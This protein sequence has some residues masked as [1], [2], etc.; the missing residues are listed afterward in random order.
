[1]GWGRTSARG[2]APGAP[3]A[4]AAVAG[5]P[6]AFWASSS[7]SACARFFQSS[8]RACLR[9]YGQFLRVH[10]RAR[11][12]ERGLDEAPEQRMGLRGLRLELGV[13]LD[14]HEPRV[15]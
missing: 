9:S 13:E 5:P 4:A 7:F 11:V 8:S 14:P 2:A 12:F 1:M 6:D 3:G 15:V 10:L